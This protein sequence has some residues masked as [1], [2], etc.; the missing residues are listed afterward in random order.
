MKELHIHRDEGHY[1]KESN[2]TW[3]PNFHAHIVVENIDRGT[4][5]SVKW[6][7]DDLSAIQDFFAEALKMERGIKSNKKHLG[8]LEYKVKKELENLNKIMKAQENT[9]NKEALLLR[10]KIF[11]DYYS[12]K[13]DFNAKLEF[14]KFLTQHPLGKEFKELIKIRK[15]TITNK[16]KGY[17]K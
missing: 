1:D 16:N 10:S 8:A 17:K 7:R 9:K 14:Q 15:T 2:N 4:G 13:L 3:K 5:K 11:S 6:N 12:N